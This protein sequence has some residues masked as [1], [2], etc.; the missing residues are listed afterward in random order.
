MWLIMN[1]AIKFKTF[2]KNKL[3]YILVRNRLGRWLLVRAKTIEFRS[4]SGRLNK[5]DFFTAD[6][7]IDPVILMLYDSYE[8][9]GYTIIRIEDSDISIVLKPGSE[10]AII[11]GEVVSIQKRLLTVH[12]IS[13]LHKLMYADTHYI[14]TKKLGN[15][16]YFSIVRVIKNI[17][18]IP[19]VPILLIGL[20]DLMN[21]YFRL[22]EVTKLVD[23][24][25]DKI[26]IRTTYNIEDIS[27]IEYDYRNFTSELVNKSDTDDRNINIIYNVA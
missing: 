25:D 27:K 8:I 7:N 6:G 23:E 10:V 22:P 26:P 14:L 16:Y 1:T 12:I 5:S 18:H 24:A 13:R 2:I 20:M 11:S 4:P 19:I 17:I 3:K 21:E 9:S 15:T